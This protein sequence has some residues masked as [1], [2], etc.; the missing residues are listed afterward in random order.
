MIYHISSLLDKYL[1]FIIAN[2]NLS[3]NTYLGYKNDISEYIKFTNV[4]SKSDLNEVDLK[5]YIKYLA[6]NFS[7]KTHCRKLSS[8]KNFYKYLFEKK[9]VVSNIFSDIEFPK[10]SKSIPKILEKNEI[11]KIIE[12]SY[13]NRSFKGQRLT[14]MIELLY[15]TGVRVSEM[16]SLKLGDINEDYSQ[17]II[18]TKGN[19]ERVI[20]IIS[21]VKCRLNNYLNELKTNFKKKKDQF[22]F[23]L[24]IQNKVTLQEIDF[25]NFYKT[26]R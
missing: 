5:S 22:L 1:E 3:K 15:A 10:S 12:K 14:L 11:L 24:L 26:L 25:F 6:K 17:I 2:K 7:K 20:P 16:V 23:F 18:N 8:V 9:T 4:K 21:S 19:K 13:E